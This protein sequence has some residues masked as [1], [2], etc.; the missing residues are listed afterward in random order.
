MCN[1][2][3]YVGTRAAAPILIDM[4]RKQEGLAGG[5]YT[6]I[7]TVH[8]GKFYHAKITG[9]IET[10]LKNTDA[11]TLPGTI[12]IIH[13]RSNGGGGD[14]WAHPFIAEDKIAYV[15]NGA[16]G[17]FAGEKEKQN[18]IAASLIEEGHT[19]L[20]RSKTQNKKYQSLE[21]GTIV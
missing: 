15:A 9:D 21:D 16:Q 4:L 11:L 19:L 17:F 18:K 6:G 12:G 3:G 20:S 13:S 10:L 1:I 8:E 7:C 2:A 14:E 5:Y